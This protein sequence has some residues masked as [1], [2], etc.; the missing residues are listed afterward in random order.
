M[1]AIRCESIITSFRSRADGSLGA[2]F[3]TP[4]LSV[5]EKVSFME[6]Q[7]ILTE[8]LIYPKDAKDADVV[9]VKKEIDSKTHSQ[10]LRGALFILWK[11]EGEKENFEAFYA[12]KMER[13]IDQIKLK[14]DGV[15]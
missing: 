9:E 14:L 6:L 1:K 12:G 10:R 4:E 7:G 8:M 15:R 13:L 5:P 2:N 11:Q 3:V